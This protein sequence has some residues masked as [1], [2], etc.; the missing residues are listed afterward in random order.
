MSQNLMIRNENAP[1]DQ[2]A[3]HW[4]AIQTATGH[5]YGMV[6]LTDETV[7]A[8]CALIDGVTMT[9]GE[10]ITAYAYSGSED[11]RC[12]GAF[13][14][15]FGLV[16]LPDDVRATARAIFAKDENGARAVALFDEIVRLGLQ[17]GLHGTKGRDCPA[18]VKG[19]NWVADEVEINRSN[20]NMG[21]LIR[22]LGLE[23]A[24]DDDTGFGEVPFGRFVKAVNDNG[25]YT[26]MELR[27]QA[28]IK[29]GE[30]QNATHV[31]WA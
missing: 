8:V 17:I 4:A 13:A 19:V 5:E 28:L 24:M 21:A 20:G 27:L 31:Y 29:A 10:T 11:D 6:T 3:I 15:G 25:R 14:S 2:A 23:D 22:D 12:Y 7:E 30:R 9:N 16:T 18:Y 1:A 26:D